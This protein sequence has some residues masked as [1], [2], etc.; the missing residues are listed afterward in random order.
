MINGIDDVVDN[1]MMPTVENDRHSA[2][3]RLQDD[4]IRFA[5]RLSRSTPVCLSQEADKR[6]SIG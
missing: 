2:F 5:L 6:Q 4:Q 3:I 1:Y